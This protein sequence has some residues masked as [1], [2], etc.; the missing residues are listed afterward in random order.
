MGYVKRGPVYDLSTVQQ[1]LQARQFPMTLANLGFRRTR[2]LGPPNH[3]LQGDGNV[4]KQND[5][6]GPYATVTLT[7]EH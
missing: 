4:K 6:S 3:T 1:R 7:D 5:V 2:P